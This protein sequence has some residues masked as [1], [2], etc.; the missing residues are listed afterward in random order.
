MILDYVIYLCLA[1]GLFFNGLGAIGLLR[2]PDV[3]TRLHAS[4]KATTFGSIFTTL[5]VIIYGLYML[6]TT[7]DMQFLILAIHA[8]IAVI[9]LAITNAIGSHAMARAAHRSGILPAQAVV[10]HLKEA[11]R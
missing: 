6:F 11:G 1:I 10:D 8:L 7:L 9:T 2:F 5:A 4:T 3:Y